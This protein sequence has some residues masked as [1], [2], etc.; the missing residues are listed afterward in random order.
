M[1]AAFLRPRF[2]ESVPEV[3][4]EGVLY[5]SMTF[6]TAMHRCACGCGEEV[7]TPLSPMDWQL[8]FD[9]ENISLEPS[10]G[11]WSFRCHSHYWIRGG[12]IRW[13]GS[14]SEAEVQG[15]RAQDLQRKSRFYA[16][17]HSTSESIQSVIASVDTA[18][19]PKSSRFQ[20]FKR[21]FRWLK[22]K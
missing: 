7:V 21:L 9:G 17:E 15:S 14:M 3:I 16:A 6:A 18:L 11:N 8:R 4:D 12:K 20:S 22:E 10:I 5:V 13:S 19:S 2:V 1:R